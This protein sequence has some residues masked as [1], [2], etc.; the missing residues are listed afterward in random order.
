MNIFKI[1]LI[2]NFKKLSQEFI[3]ALKFSV[4]LMNEP[5]QDLEGWSFNTVSGLAL[6]GLRE[7]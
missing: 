1:F 5:H 6:I 4:I 7:Q 3:L 2:V